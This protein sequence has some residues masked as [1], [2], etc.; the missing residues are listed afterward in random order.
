VGKVLG[1]SPTGFATLMII[2]LAVAAR[3]FM[4]HADFAPGAQAVQAELESKI[5]LA[6]EATTNQ[7][8]EQM[9][10]PVAVR[11][12][13]PIGIV[14]AFCGVMVFCYFRE[15]AQLVCFGWSRSWPANLIM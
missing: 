2:L 3:R 5:D 4:N 11:H 13:L 1:T 6:T 10:V 8:R 7:I 12:F 14:G 9:R 15:S